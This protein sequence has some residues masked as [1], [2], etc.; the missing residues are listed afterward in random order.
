MRLKLLLCALLFC[1]ITK[2]QTN[3]E[4]KDFINKN[5]SVLKNIQKNMIIENNTNYASFKELVKNQITAIKLFNSNNAQASFYYA[6]LVRTE[7]LK[8][9]KS[10]IPEIYKITETEKSWVKSASHNENILSETEVKTVDSQNFSD[11]QSLN[12]LTLIIQ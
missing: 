1:A 11:S 10:S 7:S 8:L 5:R 3:T 6:Y 9:L 4:L 2:A 12:N